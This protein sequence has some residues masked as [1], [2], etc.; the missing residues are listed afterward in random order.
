MGIWARTGLSPRLLNVSLVDE[1]PSA[2]SYAGETKQGKDRPVVDE[3]AM[4]EISDTFHK[5]LNKDGMSAATVRSHR[6]MIGIRVGM[7]SR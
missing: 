7:R 1:R 5:R 2:C 3:N 4:D 6:F